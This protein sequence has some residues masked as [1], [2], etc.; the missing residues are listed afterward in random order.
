MS[1]ISRISNLFVITKSYAL[2]SSIVIVIIGILGNTLNIL[3]FSNLKIFR[4]N[5]CSFYFNFE[6]IINIGALLFTFISNTLSHIGNNPAN[7]SIIWCK[8]QSMLFHIFAPIVLS[9]VCC[10]AIDQFFSTSPVVYIRQFSTLKLARYCLLITV[11]FWIIHSIPLGIFSYNYPRIGCFLSNL[12][13]IRYYLYFYYPILLGVLPISL[14]SIFSFLAF[15][16]VRRI[17]RWQMPKIRRRLDQQ[18]T[19]LVFGRVIVLVIL[20]IPYIIFYVYSFSSF[21][22]I[23]LGKFMIIQLIGTISYSLAFLNHAVN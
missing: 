2:Y 14:S 19:A 17:I 20:Y 18:M 5:I 8:I 23:D 12:T 10:T 1:S 15:R 6:S 22:T 21:K 9:T 13:F 4:G 16:N 3:V 11:C 7:Y